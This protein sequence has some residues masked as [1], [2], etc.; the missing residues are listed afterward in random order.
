MSKRKGIEKANHDEHQTFTPMLVE[1]DKYISEL[2]DEKILWDGGVT[3][4]ALIDRMGPKV[5]A[6]LQ[7]EIVLMLS[8]EG[9][10]GIDWVLMGKTMAARSQLVADKV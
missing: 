1:F 6:H 3:M 2:L 9:D 5:E 8:L 4:R 7:N 10:E